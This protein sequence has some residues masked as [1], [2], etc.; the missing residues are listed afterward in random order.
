MQIFQHEIA[1]LYIH[2]HFTQK[3]QK[4]AIKIEKTK[5]HILSVLTNGTNN[6]NFCAQ[7]CGSSANDA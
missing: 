5:I 2:I 7:I 3:A 6:K 1:A 4:N